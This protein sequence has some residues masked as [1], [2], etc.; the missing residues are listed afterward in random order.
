MA[1][2]NF[3]QTQ[4]TN[5]K[6]KSIKIFWWTTSFYIRLIVKICKKIPKNTVLEK[7]KKN[8]HPPTNSSAN[9]CTKKLLDI[10]HNPVTRP[11]SSFQKN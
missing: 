7:K 9:K 3:K 5:K 11:T 4:S 6:D 2:T 8:D 10:N 1:N